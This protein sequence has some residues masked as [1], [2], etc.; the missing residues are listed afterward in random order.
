MSKITFEGTKE[1]LNAYMNAMDRSGVCPFGSEY[2]CCGYPPGS[3]CVG[4]MKDHIVFIP[5]PRWRAGKGGAYYC[6][7]GIGAIACTADIRCETDDM[8]YEAGNY[9]ETYEQ[10]E[11]AAERVKAAYAGEKGGCNCQE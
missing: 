8:R 10:A 5:A 9:Y 6:V 11:A 2:Y 1:E 7:T 4:C 3:T